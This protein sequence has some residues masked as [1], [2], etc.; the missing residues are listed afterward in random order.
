M[1]EK[2]KEILSDMSFMPEWLDRYNYI[3]ELSDELS[4]MPDELKTPENLISG[5]QSRVWIT[6]QK[7]E[8]GTMHFSGAS[9]A[10]IVSGLLSL[11]FAAVEGMTP[12]QIEAESF[13]Y[14]DELSL[15]ENLSTTRS[16]GVASMK[17]RIKTLANTLSN[18]L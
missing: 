13:S 2:I 3:I 1:N 9:D 4:L 14:L 15:N 5:C 11:L 8:N 17:Q 6:A 12:E 18:T 16:N 7:N 10:I